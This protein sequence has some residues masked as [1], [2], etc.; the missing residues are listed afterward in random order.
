MYD[1]RMLGILVLVFNVSYIVFAG[2]LSLVGH[3]FLTRVLIGVE[4]IRDINEEILDY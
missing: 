3:P 2:L 1:Q 4:R